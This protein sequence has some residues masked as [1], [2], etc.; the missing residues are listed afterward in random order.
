MWKNKVIK[1]KAAV[2]YGTKQ[3]LIIETVDVAPPKCG[4]VRIKIAATGVS[5]HY[6]YINFASLIPLNYPVIKI[7]ALTLWK[8]HEQIFPG[9]AV[10]AEKYLSVQAP[11]AGVER[12]FSIAGHIFSL[13]RRQL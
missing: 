6:L 3:P 8:E 4:E 9:L 5:L 1:C 13:K 2:C 11:S 7:D 12:L 10:L